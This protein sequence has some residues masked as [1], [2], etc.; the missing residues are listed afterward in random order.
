[1]DTMLRIALSHLAEVEDE[2]AG[3]NLYLND[4]MPKKNFFKQKGKVGKAILIDH[5]LVSS[6]LLWGLV[7]MP[8]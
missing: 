1:M 8:G 7:W 4:L 6:D 2:A 5:L 3:D